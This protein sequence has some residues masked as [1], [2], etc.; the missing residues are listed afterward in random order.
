MAVDFSIPEEAAKAAHFWKERTGPPK[1]GS[2]HELVAKHGGRFFEGPRCWQQEPHWP[3]AWSQAKHDWILRLDADEFPS[4]TL[5]EWLVNFRSSADFPV[6]VSGYTCI[7]PLWDGTRATSSKWPN[8]RS[9]LFDRRRVQFIG[10]AEQV[11]LP[12]ATFRELNLVL[13][14]Q[15]VRKSYGVRNIVFRKQAYRWRAVIA[16]SL[17]RPP[18]TLPRWRWRSYQW[19]G[20]W[21][22]V[23]DAPLFEAFYRLIKFPLEQISNLRIAGERFSLSV[24]LNPALH[25]FLLCLEVWKMQGFSFP[26]S[27]F[28]AGFKKIILS[29]LFWIVKRYHE[30]LETLGDICPWTLNVSCLNSRSI[31]LSGGVG[32]DISFELE[33]SRRFSC[34]IALFDASPTGKTTIDLLSP[35]PV[36][37]E[38]HAKAL[39]GISGTERF[40][41]PFDAAEGSFRQPARGERVGGEWPSTSI[42]DFMKEKGW[43][44]L[45]V[46]KLDVEGFEFDILSSFLGSSISCSQLL[47]EFHYGRGT[48][49]S[50]FEYV[51]VMLRLRLAGYRL[52]HRV[53]ADHTFLHS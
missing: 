34:S 38:F 52:V 53:K 49:H 36:G 28:R 50:F 47:V 43:G 44:K 20:G 31:V 40:A 9:F 42:G 6:T 15:P 39:S 33:L 27:K 12:K 7:W 13:N 5:K 51:V 16:S 30:Q 26:M 2:T 45:D 23:I 11:P 17:L 18:I 10:M 29:I 21:L 32:G 1:P 24:C 22:G 46:L 48:G 14:H 41:Q 4:P 25:H 3:F 37:I 8:G 19:P 35:L